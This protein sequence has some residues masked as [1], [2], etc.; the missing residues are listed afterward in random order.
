MKRLSILLLMAA[1][2]AAQSMPRRVEQTFPNN[3]SVKME[4]EAGDYE[5]RAG[6]S[7]KIVIRY[8]TKTP[9]QL[10]RVDARINATGSYAKLI[11]SNAPHNDF[12]AIIEV[13]PHTGLTIRLSAGDLDVNGIEG[14]KDID[15]HAGDLEIDVISPE[16]Y[17]S[18]DAAVKAGDLSAPAFRVSKGGLFRSFRW[19]GPG[20]YRLHAN[21]GAGDLKLRTGASSGKRLE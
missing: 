18:V 1:T 3:S 21:L 19:N 17:R 14:D 16:Q 2:A 9:E 11:I 7:D 6:A 4:L 13:P 15:S 5:V 12:H 10:K 20:K 8:I